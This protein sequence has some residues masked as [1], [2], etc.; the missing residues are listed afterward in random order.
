MK[1]IVKN[2]WMSF[3]MVGVGICDLI[4]LMFGIPGR[5]LITVGEFFIATAELIDGSCNETVNSE[6]TET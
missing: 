2:A 6:E 3:K 1:N 4:G 5:I